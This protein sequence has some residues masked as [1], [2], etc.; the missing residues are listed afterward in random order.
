MGAMKERFYQEQE[1]QDLAAD[2]ALADAAECV[3]LDFPVSKFKMCPRCDEHALEHLKTHAHC[4]NCDYCEL[5][6]CDYEQNSTN[7]EYEV[8]QVENQT[9]KGA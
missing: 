4:A 3:F 1:D 9:V 8:G 2:D 7:L 5:D 6:I